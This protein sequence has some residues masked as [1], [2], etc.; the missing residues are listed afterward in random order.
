MARWADL[1]GEHVEPRELARFLRKVVDDHR[2][3]MRL[4]E[5]RM[6]Y[7][8]SVISERLSGKTRPEWVFVE[9]LIDA[10]AR[11]DMQARAR[12]KV[13]A[14]RKW[15]A[16]D[17]TRLT[18]VDDQAGTLGPLDLLVDRI[19][20][21]LQE[22]SPRAEPTEPR[23][24]FGGADPFQGPVPERN[25]YF[26]GR[27]GLSERLAAGF[28]RGRVQVLHGL[29]GVG[30]TQLAVEY[31]RRPDS[32]RELVVWIPAGEPSHAG[33][34]LAALAPRLGLDFTGPIP[35]MDAARAVMAALRDGA[36]GDRWL[37]V[38]DNAGHVTDD[39]LELIPG[40]GG[41]VLITSRDPAWASVDQV[42]EAIEVD[43]FSRAESV[44]F[45][46]RRLRRGLERE[47]YDLADAERFA[48]ALGDLPLGMEQAATLLDRFP[49]LSVVG[50][51]ARLARE[52]GGALNVAAPTAYPVTLKIAWSLAAN[53][54]GTRSP[55]ALTLLRHC[56]RRS[57][58]PIPLPAPEPG[59]P[60][61]P[62]VT[63]LDGEF[64][65]LL[66]DRF[67][68]VEELRRSGLAHVDDHEIRV[69][70]LI[71]ALVLEEMSGPETG[72]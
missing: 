18:P 41:Q 29:L 59:E 47:R 31:A 61:A 46:A 28:S 53:K 1:R 40:G 72:A 42:G 51:L 44:E 11:T 32:G 65:A 7:S 52:P 38:F 36:F 15:N 13:E 8:K 58:A 27:T 6:P 66:A 70:R 48:E 24:S 3:S 30:K 33:S 5:E 16:A 17:P 56:A 10:C 64:A 50:C 69:H 54:L 26:T 4:L 23:T 20:E 12:L 49:R 45:F 21:R 34:A 19:V 39:L 9:A 71:R 55:E 35:I 2:L 22:P 67:G 62:V 63:G 43:G 57:S 60:S 14:Q 68:A 25:R 37:L